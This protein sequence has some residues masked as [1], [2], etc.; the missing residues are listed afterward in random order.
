[1]TPKRKKPKARKPRTYSGACVCRWI[2]EPDF[3]G[4]YHTTIE[5][6]IPPKVGKNTRYFK[7]RMSEPLEPH[8][9]KTKKN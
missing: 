8:V 6:D 1:M 9:K 4:E 2:M 3:N 7:I 5:C